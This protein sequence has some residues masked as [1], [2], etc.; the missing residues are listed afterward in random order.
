MSSKNLTAYES[1]RRKKPFWINGDTTIQ[2]YKD[3][4]YINYSF[5]QVKKSEESLI[6]KLSERYNIPEPEVYEGV[7]LGISLRDSICRNYFFAS[8]KC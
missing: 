1:T 6:A 2:N 3:N 8:I 7:T 4:N 5:A